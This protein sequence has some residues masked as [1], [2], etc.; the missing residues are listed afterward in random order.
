MRPI[1]R[2]EDSAANWAARNLPLPAT[3]EAVDS[4]THRRKH[5]DGRTRWASLPYISDGIS[6]FDITNY[7]A[8][9]DGVTDD[10]AAVTAA[11]NAAIT[12]GGGTVYFPPGVTRI[13][14]TGLMDA[15]ATTANILLLGSHRSDVLLGTSGYLAFAN[16][17]VF[18]SVGINFIGTSTASVSSAISIQVSSNAQSVFEACNFYGL[19][20]TGSDVTSGCILVN[21]TP[22]VFRDCNFVGC[23]A[24]SSAVVTVYGGAGVR[25]GNTTFIDLADYKGVTYSTGVKAAGAA[26]VRFTNMIDIVAANRKTAIFENCTFDEAPLWGVRFNGTAV[27]RRHSAFFNNC[28]F[29]TGVDRGGGVYSGAIYATEM[30]QIRI[31]DTTCGFQNNVTDYSAAEFNNVGTVVIDNLQ[32]LFGAKYISLTGTTARLDIKRSTLQGN[33][34]HATGVNNAAAAAI[35]TDGG[36]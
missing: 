26:W 7:G 3:W 16:F 33:G 18:K 34:L 28:H 15:L 23:S 29:N 31:F 9:V 10:T 22:T 20:T 13:A 6:I 4:D 8:A 35:D 30:R 2:F 14:S 5:G 32:L 24:P 36:V 17:G 1:Q 19:G 11:V 27:T 21:S 25:M 12:A